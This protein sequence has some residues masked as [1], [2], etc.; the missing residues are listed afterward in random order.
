MTPLKVELQVVAVIVGIL[1]LVDTK[2][3]PGAEP[4]NPGKLRAAI[5]A[6]F[7]KPDRV[8]RNDGTLLDYKLGNGDTIRFVLDGGE[9][10]R[11]ERQLDFA[12]LV[13]QRV[14]FSGTYSGP[15]KEADFL[16]IDGGSHIHFDLDTK[17]AHKKGIKGYGQRVTATGTVRFRAAKDGGDPAKASR[18]G[19]YYLEDSDIVAVDE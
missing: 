9:S 19:L 2:G 11:I 4:R 14:S 6:R 13:G 16:A 18:A 17:R 10:I 12:R 15:G 8:Q 5:E 7:G 3:H 1:A